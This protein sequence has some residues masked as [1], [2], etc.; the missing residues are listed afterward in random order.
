MESDKVQ[1]VVASDGL[2]TV[3]GS[4]IQLELGGTA[5]KCCVHGQQKRLTTELEMIKGYFLQI[6]PCCENM[7]RHRTN[8]PHFCEGCGGRRVPGGEN[9]PKGK[10]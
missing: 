10:G 1:I 8:F 5:Q 9:L 3:D 2:R 7:F 6:C 4:K